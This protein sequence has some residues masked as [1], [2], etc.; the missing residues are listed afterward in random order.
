MDWSELVGSGWGPVVAAIITAVVTISVARLAHSS[1]RNG[2]E[3]IRTQIEIVEKLD[4]RH[5]MR[6]WLSDVSCHREGITVS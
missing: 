6:K 3:E 2:W 1:N 4:P 5:P